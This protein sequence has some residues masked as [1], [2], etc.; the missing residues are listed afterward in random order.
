MLQLTI[1]ETEFWDEATQEFITVK[2]Q[3]IQLEH[4]LISLQRWESKWKKA[5]LSNQDKTYEETMD[6][7]RC[8]TITPNVNPMVYRCFTSQQLKEINEY[9]ADP[10]TATIIVDREAKS[11]KKIITA[12]LIYYWMISFNIPFECRKWH[13]GQLLTLIR[14]IDIESRPKKNRPKKDV[15][16]EYKAI[17]EARRRELGTKG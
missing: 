2:S 6:Y 14:V 4:S 16:A 8:M 12:E 17:N 3:T 10:M 9:I 5:F 7:I 1:P 15:L 11:G 13:L